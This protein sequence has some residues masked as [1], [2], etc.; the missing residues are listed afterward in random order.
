MDL[1]QKKKNHKRVTECDTQLSQR[2]FGSFMNRKE[3][4]HSP[5]GDTQK[6][7]NLL[8]R[9]RKETRRKF[10]RQ[11]LRKTK[12]SYSYEGLRKFINALQFL[13]VI[14]LYLFHR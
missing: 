8:L 3:E 13:I 12:G 11:K 2:T 7:E 14:D 6:H 9:L 1:K 4:M 10:R 5:N